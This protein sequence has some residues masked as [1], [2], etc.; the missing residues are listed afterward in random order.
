MRIK[1]GRCRGIRSISGQDQEEGVPRNICRQERRKGHTGTSPLALT[2][3]C[4]LEVGD[5]G[6]VGK[7]GPM[8]LAPEGIGGHA[9]RSEEKARIAREKFCSEKFSRGCQRKGKSE[10]KRLSSK[11]KVLIFEKNIDNPCCRGVTLAD[12]GGNAHLH[13]RRR[14]YQGIFN[15]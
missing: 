6:C 8:K 12:A 4:V 14:R 11:K 1:N 3:R 10:P 13:P 7:R 2:W 9:D 15:S 5:D